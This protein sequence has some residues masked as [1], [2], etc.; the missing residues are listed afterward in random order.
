MSHHTVLVVEDEHALADVLTD[1][2]RDEGYDVHVAHDGEAA[3][4]MWREAQPDLVILDI[5]LP[6]I[7]GLD[8]CQTRR[9]EGDDTPVLFLSALG[10]ADERVAGLE[11]GGDDYLAK[12]FHLPEFLLRVRA[13]LRR[14]RSAPE[15]T[16]TFGGHE[17]D[18]LAWRASLAGGHEESLSERELGLL[19][20]LA[21]RAGEVVPRDDILDEVWGD[22]VF[23]SSRTVDNVVLRLRKLFEPNPSEPVFI[24][25][26]WG[27]GYRFTPEGTP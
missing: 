10:Q 20:L 11:A 16:L 9:N 18:L 17:V 1:N 15:R 22:D 3:L 5:M 8:V 4:T 6:A 13:L 25:T 26:V 12:P 19:K 23:P 24:H 21:S 7:N 27:V 2:L 14:G